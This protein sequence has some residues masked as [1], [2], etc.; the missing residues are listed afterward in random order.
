[1]NSKFQFRKNF[2]IIRP[3]FI[4]KCIFL[5]GGT[6]GLGKKGSCRKWSYDMS[7][8]GSWFKKKPPQPY[9]LPWGIPGGDEIGGFFCAL[10]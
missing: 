2:D 3:Y 8:E 4:A 7:L 9:P 6:G 10:R 1:M 5:T